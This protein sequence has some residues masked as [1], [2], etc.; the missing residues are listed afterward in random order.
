MR[1]LGTKDDLA[2]LVS[3]LQPDLLLSRQVDREV[4]CLCAWF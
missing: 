3:K 4:A 2:D 1:S